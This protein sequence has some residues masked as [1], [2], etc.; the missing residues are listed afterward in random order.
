MENL[1]NKEF[2]VRSTD[3]N[4]VTEAVKAAPPLTVGGLTMWGVGLSEWVL[5]LT[6]IYTVLQIYFLLRDRL[7]Q[8][9]RKKDGSE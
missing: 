2:R 4:A 5:I 1:M 7:G 6:A 9:H 3:L 8:K